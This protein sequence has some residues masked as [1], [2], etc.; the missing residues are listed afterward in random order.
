M[1]LDD[2]ARVSF[3]AAGQGIAC[4]TPLEAGI[5]T[6]RLTDANCTAQN[7]TCQMAVITTE[8]G[9]KFIEILVGDEGNFASSDVSICANGLAQL[10][11]NGYFTQ[12]EWVPADYLS[13]AF[14]PNPIASPPV[15][16]TFTVNATDGSGCLKIDHVTV[17]VEPMPEIAAAMKDAGCGLANGQVTL[18]VSGGSGS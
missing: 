15:T 14:V 8:G 4:G 12:I 11:A 6:V 1:I 3:T 2:T 10:S 5:S 9:E 17:T 7:K 18:M 13:D 16:T